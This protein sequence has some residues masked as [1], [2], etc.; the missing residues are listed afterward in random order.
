VRAKG[1]ATPV[2]TWQALGGACRPGEVD[3]P[4]ESGTKVVTIQAGIQGSEVTFAEVGVSD[5]A[6]DALL[7]VLHGGVMTVSSQWISSMNLTS[8]V[9]VR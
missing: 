3:G 9:A 7:P 1:K 2:P 4:Y 5:R 6:E 8:R